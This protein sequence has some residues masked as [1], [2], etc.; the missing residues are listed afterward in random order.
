MCG[1]H[2]TY[3]N[4]QPPTNHTVRTA[5]KV[6]KKK[7][8][9]ELDLNKIELLLNTQLKAFFFFFEYWHDQYTN[10]DETDV[11]LQTKEISHEHLTKKM[12][13]QYIVKK[14]KTS[15]M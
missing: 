9:T 4:I 15:L 8:R 12:H 6:E 2:D 14:K 7:N 5:L 3:F 13:I 10:S 1:F 11:M